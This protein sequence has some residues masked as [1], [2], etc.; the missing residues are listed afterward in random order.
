[1][2]RSATARGVCFSLGSIAAASILGIGISKADTMPFKA[3][4]DISETVEPNTTIP[5]PC[6][7][8]N[9]PTSVGLRGDINGKGNAARLGKITT[10]SVDCIVPLN[11]EGT[12]FIAFSAQFAMTGA[13]GDQIFA[14]YTAELTVSASTGVGALRGQFVISGGTGAFTH[15][16][17]AGT[18]EGFEVIRFSGP[19]SGTGQGRIVLNGILTF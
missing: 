10:T 2:N 11:L 19:F 13:N 4:I 9:P 7:A 18:L 8:F 14:S 5:A 12:S 1:M 3:T 16:T 17:G 15:A 6:P